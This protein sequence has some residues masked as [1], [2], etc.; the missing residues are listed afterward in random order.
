MY[1]KL[2]VILFAIAMGDP[3]MVILTIVAAILIP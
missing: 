2:L 3:G 1:F